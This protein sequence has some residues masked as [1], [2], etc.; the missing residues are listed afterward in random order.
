MICICYMYIY[1]YIHKHYKQHMKTNTHRVTISMCIN[2]TMPDVKGSTQGL[3]RRIFACKDTL[4]GE[5]G[6]QL[7][8]GQKQ[9]VAIARAE[10]PGK[11]SGLAGLG[12]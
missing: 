10:F 4:V 3:V 9:R 12:I 5:R 2:H 1:I 11:Q 7:S 8:G 6:I